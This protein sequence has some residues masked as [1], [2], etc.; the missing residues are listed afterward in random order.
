MLARIFSRMHQNAPAVQAAAGQRLFNAGLMRPNK[1]MTILE[2][3]R[4]NLVR[5]I[6]LINAD[7]QNLAAVRSQLVP[8]HATLQAQSVAGAV[9]TPDANRHFERKLIDAQIAGLTAQ[10]ACLTTYF[11][12]MTAKNPPAHTK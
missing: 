11:A 9:P 4:L 8:M 10:R 1:P 3:E 5:Q 7:I 12:Q 2:V 6:A